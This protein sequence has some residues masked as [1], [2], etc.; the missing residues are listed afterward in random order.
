MSDEEKAAKK[1]AAMRAEL[2]KHNEYDGCGLG[3]SEGPYRMTVLEWTLTD[4]VSASGV[5]QIPESSAEYNS[6]GE[7][8]VIG[9]AP[10]VMTLWRLFTTWPHRHAGLSE[11][12]SMFG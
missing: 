4:S 9:V 2:S 10:T 1:D 7:G 6:R 12:R 5:F 3:S 8:V 11:S